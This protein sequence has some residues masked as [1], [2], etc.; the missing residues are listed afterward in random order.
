MGGIKL[1]RR[2][3][4]HN[5]KVLN[6]NESQLKRAQMEARKNEKVKFLNSSVWNRLKFFY[7]HIPSKK[8]RIMFWMLSPM[9]T[10]FLIPHIIISTLKI[11][12]AWKWSEQIMYT[13]KNG[14]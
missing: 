3:L 8:G 10:A 9:T 14:K 4:K 13:F 1:N 2:Q 11:D 6:A 7:K 5:A 12:I